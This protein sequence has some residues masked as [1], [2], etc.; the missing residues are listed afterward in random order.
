MNIHIFNIAAPAFLDEDV[1]LTRLS[2]CMKN[3][4]A[5]LGRAEDLTDVDFEI[6]L[7]PDRYQESSSLAT[8]R[9]QKLLPDMTVVWSSLD[10]LKNMQSIR[11][12]SVYVGSDVHDHWPRQDH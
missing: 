1:F 2:L 11:S 5:V 3:L 8:W 12:I 7:W 6:F 9:G 4:V 10:P